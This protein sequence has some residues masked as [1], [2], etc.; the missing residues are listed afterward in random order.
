MSVFLLVKVILGPTQGWGC[1]LGGPNRWLEAGTF[2]CISPPMGRSERL[3]VESGS[4]QWLSKLW[5]PNEASKKNWKGQF[6]WS[7][8]KKLPECTRY[9]R[10]RSQDPGR[11][12]L[13]CSGPAL[14]ISSPGCWFMSFNKLVNVF[15]WVLWATPANL[16]T[17]QTNCLVRSTGNSL[18]L[19]LGLEWGV[20]S[21]LARLNS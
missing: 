11:Q 21:R 7:L 16:S 12:M 3:E 5:L 20:G 10:G 14:S 15:S 2:S 4:G 6:F 18:W 9:H 13:H 19:G 17:L 8:F 1:L